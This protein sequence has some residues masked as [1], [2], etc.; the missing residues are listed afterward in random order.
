MSKVSILKLSL[1]PGGAIAVRQIHCP[2]QAAKEDRQK[3]S[4]G[5]SG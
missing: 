5:C 2:V 3:K 1:F 4:S